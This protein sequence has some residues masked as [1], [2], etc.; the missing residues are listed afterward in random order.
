MRTIQFR[1]FVGFV[2]GPITDPDKKTS[3]QGDSL[4]PLDGLRGLAVL[5]VIASH[6]SAFGMAGQGGIGVFLFFMLSGFVLTVPFA[7]RNELSIS[8]H[9]T[10]RF[11]VNRILRIYPAYT[12][13]VLIIARQ[14]DEGGAWIA[15]SLAMKLGWFHL[16]TVLEEVR[17]YLYFPLVIFAVSLLKTRLM[18]CAGLV[19]LIVVARLLLKQ[20]SPVYLWLFMAGILACLIYETD[21]VKR[22]MRTPVAQK[23]LGILSFA[24]LAFIVFSAP[25]MRLQTHLERYMHDS[26]VPEL[27]CFVF[28]VLLFGVMFAPNSVAAKWMSSWHMRNI[29]LLSYGL[30]LFH[31]PVRTVMYARG[32]DNA[33][34]FFATFAVTY[35][36]AYVSYITIE[37]PFQSLKPK[38]SFQEWIG[39]FAWRAS[40]LTAIIAALGLAALT[41]NY[42]AVVAR[43]H[44]VNFHVAELERSLKGLYEKTNSYP[45][46]ITPIGLLDVADHR[47]WRATPRN[48]FLYGSDGT[49]F[50]SLLVRRES[51]TSIFAKKTVS[52]CAIGSSEKGAD[53]WGV[54]DC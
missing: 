44:R 20:T 6:T 8:W 25:E 21:S 30:Y 49:S 2:L 7:R 46:G 36:V 18:Q 32:L 27:W 5:I 34:L 37:K 40:A 38:T 39:P 50:Y 13:A 53:M 11:F 48:Q 54:A 1:E 24:A 17:F 22:L 26:I 31:V 15:Y 9:E 45:A 14:L 41:A 42:A 19:V 47:F 29:G 52:W 10:W 35:V 43:Q 4:L 12:V 23:L 51:I 28:A 3:S 16:W 33:G